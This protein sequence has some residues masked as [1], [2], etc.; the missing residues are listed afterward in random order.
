MAV[1]VMG[2]VLMARMHCAIVFQ[3]AI[4]VIVA[5]NLN[6]SFFSCSVPS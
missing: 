3:A 2:R 6:L 5:H 1:A 4:L